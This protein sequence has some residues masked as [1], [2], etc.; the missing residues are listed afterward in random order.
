M[1]GAAGLTVI[2]CLFAD[3]AGGT[4]FSAL[5][6]VGAAPLSLLA[7]SALSFSEPGAAQP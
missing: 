7:L 3:G 5:I 1:R 2:T 6:S 4:G